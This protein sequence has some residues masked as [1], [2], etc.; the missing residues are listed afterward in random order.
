MFGKLRP[1]SAYDVMAALSLFIVLGGTSYAVAAGSIDSREIKNGQVKRVDLGVDSVDSR[2]VR[3]GSLLANDFRV[4][5]LPAGP[6]G[7]RGFVGP[8]GPQGAAGPRGAQGARGPA[9]A[10]NVVIRS[11]SANLIATAFCDAG[12]RA[13]GGGA[14]ARRNGLLRT[15]LPVGYT[16]QT[17]W[18]ASAETAAGAAVEVSV[19]AICTSP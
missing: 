17:G 8:S 3:S 14:V 10:T 16:V 2:K 6:P 19:Y 11:A 13:T 18:Q 4:G 5:Q 9:G 7:P 1:R 15:S 12:Q